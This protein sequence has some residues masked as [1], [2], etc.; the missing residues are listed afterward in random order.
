MNLIEE[1]EAA[2]NRAYRN[3]EAWRK[4]DNK[5]QDELMLSLVYCDSG[6]WP[7]IKA[8]LEAAQELAICVDIYH[9]LAGGCGTKAQLAL[10]QFRAAME[11]EK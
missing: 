1:I 8:A 4:G 3:S 5:A 6:R 7:R 10:D 9:K 2:A 11:G